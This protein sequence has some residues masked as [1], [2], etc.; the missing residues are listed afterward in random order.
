[1]PVIRET[2]TI[3]S[4]GQV[5]MP[6]AIRQALG[7]GVGDKVHFELHDGRVMVTNAE[8]GQ[9]DPAIAA[10]LEL[11]EADLRAGR[12]MHELPAELADSMLAWV[13]GAGRDDLDE[14][15]EGDVVI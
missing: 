7:V 5:T 13:A 8:A 10:F 3:T 15:I 14:V 11:L 9:D 4:K 6:K 12:N 2:S 1:M